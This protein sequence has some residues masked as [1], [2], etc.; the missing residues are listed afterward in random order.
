[1]ANFAVLLVVQGG[2]RKPGKGKNAKKKVYQLPP[3]PEDKVMIYSIILS[4]INERFVS[5]NKIK[6][7]SGL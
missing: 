5:Q 4:D 6:C 7:V 2:E 1:V 3:I